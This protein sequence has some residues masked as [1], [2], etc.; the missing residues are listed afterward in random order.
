MICQI[1]SNYTQTSARATMQGVCTVRWQLPAENSA[2]KLLSVST[3]VLYVLT[4]EPKFVFVTFTDMRNRRMTAR[5]SIVLRYDKNGTKH[6]GRPPVRRYCRRFCFEG[7][8]CGVHT[9]APGPVCSSAA[10]VKESR[11]VH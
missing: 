6:A 9:D 7:G 2:N 11:L 3:R 4:A 5:G 10:M 1:Q 8:T